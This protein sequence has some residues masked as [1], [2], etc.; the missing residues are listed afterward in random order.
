MLGHVN[1]HIGLHGFKTKQKHWAHWIAAAL[2]LCLLT[3]HN[4]K[5]K[6]RLRHGVCLP[7]SLSLR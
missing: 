1:L 6:D 4:L 5:E 2:T 7:I 3:T